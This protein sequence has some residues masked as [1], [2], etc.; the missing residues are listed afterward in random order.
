MQRP[1]KT[2]RCINYLFTIEKNHSY[3]NFD[4]ELRAIEYAQ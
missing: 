3:E 4:N 2:G 1:V